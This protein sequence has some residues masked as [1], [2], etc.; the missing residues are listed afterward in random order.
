M[1][2][3]VFFGEML[4]CTKI[5]PSPPDTTIRSALDHPARLHH[6]TKFRGSKQLEM[7]PHLLD[8]FGCCGASARGMLLAGLLVVGEHHNEPYQCSR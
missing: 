6:D 2:G 8:R 3:G 1:E 7:P 4:S 5:A